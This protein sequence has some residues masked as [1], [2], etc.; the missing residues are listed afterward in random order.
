MIISFKKRNCNG[1]CIQYNNEN[2]KINNDNNMFC[3]FTRVQQ[4]NSRFYI[5]YRDVLAPFLE[6]I[7][8][9]ILR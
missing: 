2:N 1:A 7:Y 9:L 3:S 8:M 6:I 4:N 5:K